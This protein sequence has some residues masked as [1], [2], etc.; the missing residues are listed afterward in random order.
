MWPPFPVNPNSLNIFSSLPD[1]SQQYLKILNGTSGTNGLLPSGYT[2]PPTLSLE[3]SPTNARAAALWGGGVLIH[4][5]WVLTAAHC[6]KDGYRVYLGKD[7]LGHVE[8]G[9]QVREVV[10]SIPTLYTRSSSVQLTS[11]IQIPPFSH[12]DCLP[13]GTCCLVSGWGTTTS[14]QGLCPHRWPEVSQSGQG[15]WGREGRV[16]WKRSFYK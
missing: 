5:R 15:S 13:A 14:P 9:E 7:A 1:I 4:P 12:H 16:G 11:H 8:D 2:C 10:R 6:L 3:G